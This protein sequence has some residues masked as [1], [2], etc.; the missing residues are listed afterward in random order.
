[1]NLLDTLRELKDEVPP[2]SQLTVS[3]Q[4][5][6]LSTLIHYLDRRLAR[7]EALYGTREVQGIRSSTK[8]N[9]R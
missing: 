7:L 6:V 3:E 1:M 8:D 2:S 4:R 5:E 9:R